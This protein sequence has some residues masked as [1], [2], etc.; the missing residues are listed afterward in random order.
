[1]ISLYPIKF[2]WDL[3]GDTSNA[4]IIT[5]SIMYCITYELFIMF[6]KSIVIY[7]N[8]LNHNIIDCRKLAINEHK[9][10]DLTKLK[11]SIQHTHNYRAEF[12]IRE[13]NDTQHMA[14]D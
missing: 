7:L 9:S 4:A 13:M 10:I 1:M 5:I 11:V 14:S 3:L 8:I 6:V 2:L 12:I